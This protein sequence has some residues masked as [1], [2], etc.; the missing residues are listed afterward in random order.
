MAAGKHL[1]DLLRAHRDGDDLAFRRAADALIVAEESKN[2]SVLARELRRIV[3]LPAAVNFDLPRGGGVDSVPTSQ[4]HGTPLGFVDWPDRH[5]GTLVLAIDTR[6][7]LKRFVSEVKMWPD[8]DRQGI[9]RRRTLLLYGPPGCGKTSAASAVAAELGRPLV[10]ARL[11]TLI[12]S[13]LGETANNI[14]RLFQYAEEQR[15]VL[16]LDEFDTIGKERSDPGDHGELHRVVNAVLQLI[17]RMEGQSIVIAATNHSTLLD[18]AA[19][20]RFNEVVEMPLPSQAAISQVLRGQLLGRTEGD[21]DLESVA[22]MLIGLPHAAAEAVAF[23]ARRSAVM[24]GRT[25]VTSDDLR[26][27]VTRVTERAWT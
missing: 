27:A 12:S 19:W 10:T 3:S 22:G 6:G 7:A 18:D 9:P 13:F 2:H 24:S 15:C 26:Q 16:F 14:G 11:D 4:D 25:V 8:F 20:R 1:K 23:D 21:V 5:L 17:D